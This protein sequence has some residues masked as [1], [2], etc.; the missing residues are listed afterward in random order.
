M[1][2]KITIFSIGENSKSI[3]LGQKILQ[4][5]EKCGASSDGDEEGAALAKTSRAELD[6]GVTLG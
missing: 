2:G 1:N 5:S 4:K 3:Q 6:P